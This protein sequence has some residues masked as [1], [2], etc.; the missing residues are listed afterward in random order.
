VHDLQILEDDCYAAGLPGLPALRAAA[1]E[2]TWL[3][4]SLS[5][6]VAAGLRF[7]AVLCP[8]GLGETARLA[9]QHGYFGLSAPILDIV[10]RLLVSGRAAELRTAVQAEF[11]R[12]LGI[13]LNALGRFDVSWQKGLAF[14]WLKLPSGWRASTFTRTAEA[15]GVLIRSSDEYAL[16][17]GHA[18]NAVRI[19][20]AG[21]V[22]ED[23]FAGAMATLARLLDRPP[24]SFFD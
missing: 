19:A 7:G 9:T 24:N 13:A 21:D 17:D 20:L 16:V 2:R 18:P 11:D 23:R 5:K 3:I 1:P 8:S 12:R 6:S 14:V 15:E 10:Q 4:A 22:P